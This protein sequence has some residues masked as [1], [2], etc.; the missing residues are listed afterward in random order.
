MRF[1]SFHRLSGTG[2]A[3][4]YSLL[5]PVFLF[6]NTTQS[7]FGISW[8]ICALISSLFLEVHKVHLR[9]SAFVR[10]QIFSGS[11]LA[12]LC[13][14][15]FLIYPDFFCLSQSCVLP[16]SLIDS[17][18]R[19]RKFNPAPDF[20]GAVGFVQIALVFVTR[21]VQYRFFTGFRIIRGKGVSR[22]P[23][24]RSKKRSVFLPCGLQ[25]ASQNQ[26]IRVPLL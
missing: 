22:A 7:A 4:I 9:K 6:G 19:F 8:K 5:W 16:C 21:A 2:R 18:F 20:S 3:W 17:I 10:I 11:A 25:W 24:S 14:I 26:Y 12:E 15:A 1:V 23:L 13:G